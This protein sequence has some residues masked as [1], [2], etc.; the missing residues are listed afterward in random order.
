[1][2]ERELML[3]G[4]LYLATDPEL[5]SLRLRAQTLSHRY[6][7]T[8]PQQVQERRRILDE[9]FGAL[10]KDALIEPPFRCDYGAQ[11]RAG[12]KLFINYDCIILDCAP[13]EFGDDVLVGPRVQILTATHPI[14]PHVRLLGREM[15][16]P[17]RIGDGAWIGAGAILCP[18]V[19]VGAGAVVGAGSVVITDVPEGMLAVGNPARLVRRVS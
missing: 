3:S 17:I 10:G 1:M 19:S 14:D 7:A 12:R 5:V 11:I 6:N 4:G 2:T 13:V 18:G 8:E 9:L 15:A 16:K